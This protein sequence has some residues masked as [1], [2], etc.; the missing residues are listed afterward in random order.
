MGHSSPASE[1]AAGLRALPGC[2]SSASATQAAWRFYSNPEITLPQ[3]AEP[4]IQAARTAVAQHCSRYVV[5]ALDWTRLDYGA[6]PSKR[7]R[8]PLQN[9]KDLGYKLLTALAVSDHGGE[10][11]APLCLEL[12]A[13]DG[14]HTTR[15]DQLLHPASPLDSLEPVMAHM[16]SLDLGRPIVH[17]IDREADSV[18]HYRCWNAQKH[19]FVVRADDN[20]GVVHAGANKRLKDV[21]AAVEFR[22]TREVEHEGRGALQFV[23]ETVVTLA[24]DASR[25]RTKKGRRVKEKIPGEALVLRLVVSEVRDNSGRVLSRW[26]LLTNVPAEVDAATV[27]LW[28]YW[29]WRIESY[30]K[31]LKSSGQRVESWLQDDAGALARRLLVS[32][33][34]CVLVWRLARDLSEQ[35]AVLRN[36]LVR[37]SGRQMKRGKRE[38]GFTEPALLAGLSVLLPM[39]QVL[40]VMTAEE[41]K[42]LAR[43]ILP[44]EWLGGKSG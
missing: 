21:A 9:K 2:A 23:G 40:E 24:R 7:D 37:L 12:Q 44:I 1:I 35:A 39:L 28:Y 3:L 20:P 19:L 17:V 16:R 6:H 31:L 32:A 10:P 13:R 41:L 33:M 30:H 14:V 5:V 4:L 11:I 26:L 8:I 29:R 43:S 42:A 25:H 38:R 18:L 34:A 15:Q 22:F 27:A 36:L